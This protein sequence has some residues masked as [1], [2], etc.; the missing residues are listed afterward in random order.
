MTTSRGEKD[1]RKMS[2]YYIDFSEGK[3]S[4]FFEKK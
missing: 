3:T 1:I 2:L 4:V